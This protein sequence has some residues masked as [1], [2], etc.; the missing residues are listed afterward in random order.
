MAKEEKVKE[1]VVKDINDYTDSE[2]LTIVLERQKEN[3]LISNM[4]FTT[5]KMTKKDFGGVT[6]LRNGKKIDKLPVSGDKL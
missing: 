2:L 4:L 1:T 3:S 6:I 5:I